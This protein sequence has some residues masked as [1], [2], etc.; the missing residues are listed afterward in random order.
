MSSVKSSAAWQHAAPAATAQTRL[1]L[2]ASK[3]IPVPRSIIEYTG[4]VV[5]I[6]P[7]PPKSIPPFFQGIQGDIIV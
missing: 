4:I 1:Y 2:D 5:H 3:T 6:P 7:Y